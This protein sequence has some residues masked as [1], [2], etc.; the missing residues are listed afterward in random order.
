MADG[1]TVIYYTS[2]MLPRAASA[3]IR[4]VL[5]AS[6]DGLPIISVSQKPLDFGH[7]ICIGDIGASTRNLYHQ[8]LM[9]AKAAFTDHI[10]LCEDDCL[11]PPSHF[12]D[13]RPSDFGYNMNRWRVHTWDAHPVFSRKN[14]CGLHQLICPRDLLIEHLEERFSRNH[15]EDQINHHWGEPGR[16]NHER[17]LGVSH[18]PLS[19]WCSAEPCVVFFHPYSLN[20]KKQGTRVAHGRDGL[21]ETLAPWGNA[22][23]VVH[24]FWGESCPN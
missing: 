10:A 4:A 22:S 2:G 24:K 7:N 21:V 3:A 15:T 17:C 9:G 1:L 5:S 8:V 11:Y 23:D 19:Q 12:T 20:Y 16:W 18:R 13:A 6:C 14:R